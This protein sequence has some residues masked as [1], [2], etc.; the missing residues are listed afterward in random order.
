MPSFFRL[1]HS[2]KKHSSTTVGLDPIVDEASQVLILGSLPSVKSLE[3]Q[4]YY[5][6][7]QNRFW[8]VLASVVGRQIPIDYPAKLDFLR[9]NHVALWDVI[10]HADRSGSLDSNISNETVNDIPSLL[11]RYPSI[12]TIALNGSKAADTF[13][14]YFN[15]DNLGRRVNIMRLPS[16]SSANT[17]FTLLQMSELWRY[18]FDYQS[19]SL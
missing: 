2:L 12:H 13:S 14:R 11:R 9:A 18:I 1:F 4:E 5:G 15:E 7:P 8:R 6:N 16:T 19:I 3:K 17:R 10:E